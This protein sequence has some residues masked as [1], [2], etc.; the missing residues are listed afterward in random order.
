MCYSVF[1]LM[2]Q[3]SQ[4]PTPEQSKPA[5]TGESAVIPSP[6]MPDSSSYPVD[7]GCSTPTSGYG[8]Y[9]NNT[10]PMSEGAASPEAVP[11]EVFEN[12]HFSPTTTQQNGFVQSPSS[13]Y[14]QS[15]SSA[16][17][18]SPTKSYVQ[19]PTNGY[20]QSP[21]SDYQN[22]GYYSLTESLQQQQQPYRD[23]QQQHFYPNEPYCG[24]GPFNNNMFCYNYPQTCEDMNQ[25]DPNSLQQQTICRVCGDTASGNHFGV[26][27]CEACKSFFRRSIRANARYAC[28]GNRSCAIEKH[29]R[30]RCQYCR[31][32]KCVANGMRKEGELKSHYEGGKG[33]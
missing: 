21:T 22:G 4:I 3:A 20:V 30:N 32:Q 19:S 15:P 17:V 28:R 6:P 10:S 12:G 31:L 16:Y 14:V 33:G 7:S 29:T 13:G 23:H 11:V 25:K 9:C 8:S 1:T 18:Q 27:S 24:Y 2:G 26:Q 5:Y